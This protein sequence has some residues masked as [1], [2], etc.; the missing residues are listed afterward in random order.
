M[1]NIFLS[2]PMPV[3]NGSGAPVDVSAMGSEKSIV[4]GGSF[5]GA[6]VA[7]EVSTDGG[8]TFLPIWLFTT[9]SKKVIPVAA[10]FMRVFVSGRSAQ[11]F[12]AAVNIGANDSGALFVGLDRKSVV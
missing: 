1:A 9:A 11:P 6:S 7:I 5:V 3:G 8:T 10:Q 12:S 4:I 2:L